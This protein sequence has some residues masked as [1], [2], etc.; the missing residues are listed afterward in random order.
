MPAKKVLLPKVGRPLMT[1]GYGISKTPNG[2]LTWDYVR[3]QMT[4]A[5]NYWLA[6]TRPD[7]RAHVMPVWGLWFDETFCFGTDPKSKKARNLAKNPHAIVHL[8]SGDDVVIIE[9]LVDIVK[10]S[11]IV[12]RYASK[13][14]AKYKFRPGASYHRLKPSV[15]LAWREKDFPRTATR[16]KF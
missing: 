5:R 9:G 12:K 6:T 2:M 3:K 8:E 14:Y 7:G 1:N 15:V 4:G 13:Y 11:P 16:W 10:S